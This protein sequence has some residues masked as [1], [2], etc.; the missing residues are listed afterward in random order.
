MRTVRLWISITEKPSREDGSGVQEAARQD[1]GRLAGH[2]AAWSACLAGSWL[3][4]GRGQEPQ[5]VPNDL[6][7]SDDRPI[8][9]RA[10]RRPGCVGRTL[11][12]R[13]CT[14]AG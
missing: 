3:E 10:E 7:R 13:F 6:S 1:A 5:R 12:A 4:A 8:N 14:P 2:K 11:I 9:T